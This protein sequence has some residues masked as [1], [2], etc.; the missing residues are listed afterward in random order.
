MEQ[1][2]EE[3]VLRLT[4]QHAEV[5][6]QRLHLA[7]DH[8]TELAREGIEKMQVITQHQNRQFQG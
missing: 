3:T 2:P 7:C 8:G 4:L 5:G 6:I 1:H